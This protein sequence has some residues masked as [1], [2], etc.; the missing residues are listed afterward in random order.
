M[1]CIYYVV[2]FRSSEIQFIC[3]SCGND[4]GQPGN[5]PAC[6]RCII[7]E[8][9]FQRGRNRVHVGPAAV[10]VGP[11][12]GPPTWTE[13]ALRLL[14]QIKLE[15]WRMNYFLYRVDHPNSG[16]SPPGTDEEDV[17][18]GQAEDGEAELAAAALQYWPDS[19]SHENKN[20]VN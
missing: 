5:R 3:V 1:L 17:S 8:Q 19:S 11:E 15:R 2:M 7:R 9:M 18:D 16:L 12:F 4:F 10:E 20:R 14:E 13:Y 6:N